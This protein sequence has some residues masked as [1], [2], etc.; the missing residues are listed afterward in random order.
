M[1][2]KDCKVTVDVTIGICVRDSERTIREAIESIVNQSFDKKRMEI[3]VIDDG[4][5]DQTIPIIT[6]ILSKNNLTL[7]IFSTN[8]GGLT[9]ARQMVIDNSCAYLVIFMDAD[10]FFP[11]DF[12]QKQVELM[13]KTPSIGVAQGTMIGRK[14]RSPIAELEDLS[15]SSSFEIGIHR[16]WRRNPQALGTGGSIFRVAAV[17]AVGGFDKRIKGA[18]EDADL[19]IKIK[20]KG[21]SLAISDAIF[22]H[23]FKRNLKSLWKQ[24][25]WYGFGMHYFYH[26]HGSIK[27]TMMVYFWPVTYAWSLIRAILVFRATKKKIAFFLPSYNFFRATAWW[28]GFLDAHVKGYG[29][30]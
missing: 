28:F 14:S 18:A 15:F 25:T 26:K 1:I 17:K 29:H 19:T 16:N 3:V 9:K 6:N 7:R 4:C 20:N 5:K 23:E 30:E 2:M 13:E 10:M 27:D 12:V 8:G 11:Q 24:Y 21:Y 22:E